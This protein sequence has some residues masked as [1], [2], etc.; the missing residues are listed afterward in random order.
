MKNRAIDIIAAF[1]FTTA[2]LSFGYMSFGIWPTM[3]FM[4]GFLGGF[5]LWLIVPVKTSFQSIKIPFWVTFL[6]FMVH[7][8]EEKVSGFFAALSDITDVPT[9]DI[10]SVPVILL[11]LTSVGAWFFVPYLMKRKQAFGYYLAWTFFC[12]MGITE[13]A[14][15]VFPLFLDEPYGYFPGMVSVLVLAPA[16]WWGIARFIKKSDV[17]AAADF[18]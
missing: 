4:S 15:F 16:A 17:R 8:V 14:H 18:E 11:V 2:V 13:L 1:L 3:I 10:I 9:P 12:A 7:R 5:I 6:L